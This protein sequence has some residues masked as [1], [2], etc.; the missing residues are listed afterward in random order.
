MA[1]HG[2]QYYPSLVHQHNTLSQ[3][4]SLSA[5]GTFALSTNAHDMLTNATTHD[6]PSPPSTSSSSSR[7]DQP[8]VFSMPPALPAQ[9]TDHDSYKTRY[10]R[11]PRYDP[12]LMEE[13]ID[14]DRIVIRHQI[15]RHFHEAVKQRDGARPYRVRSFSFIQ[16]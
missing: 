5:S 4:P 10:E 14:T 1:Q 16:E 6:S 13:E 2:S 15:R 7:L 12:A 8:P 9:A 3:P 11:D